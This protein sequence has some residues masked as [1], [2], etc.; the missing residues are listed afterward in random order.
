MARTKSLGREELEKLRAAI[1]EKFRK[2]NPGLKAVPATT[3]KEAYEDIRDDIIRVV[4]GAEQSVSLIR[5]RKL[6]YYTDPSVCDAEQLENASFGKDFL[7]ALDVYTGKSRRKRLPVSPWRWAA[8]LLT[9]CTSGFIFWLAFGPVTPANV[10]EPFNDTDPARLKREGWE[11]LDFDTANWR[12][13]PRPGMLALYTL[14]GDYWVKPTE[15]RRIANLLVHELPGQNSDVS[16][17]LVD[18]YPTQNHQQAGFILFDQDKSRLQHVRVTFGFNGPY[19]GDPND[20]WPDGIPAVQGISLIHTYPNGDV[21]QHPFPLVE[22]DPGK[23]DP[24][25]DT[26]YLRLTL[27]GKKCAVYYKTGFP[28]SQYNLLTTVDLDFAPA[29]IGIAAFQGWTRDD[30]TPK[31]ADTIPAFFDWVEVSRR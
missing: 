2:R 8:I 6:F 29:Y 9:M 27:R 7:H 11:I 24:S 10:E 5:L 26:I 21:I 18:F 19:P 13:Q 28:W 17:R 20:R 30:Y 25:M 4:P 12:R 3:Y 31:G 22:I 14:P 15:P 23:P 1:R 16:T